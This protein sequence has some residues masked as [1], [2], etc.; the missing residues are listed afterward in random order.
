MKLNIEDLKYLRGL[1]LDDGYR[2]VYKKNNDFHI[3]SYSKTIEGFIC[4]LNDYNPYSLYDEKKF[5]SI[6]KL[7]EEIAQKYNEKEVYIYKID[8]TLISSY[9]QDDINKSE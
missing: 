2:L 5:I 4:E 9:N 7:L 8:G 6:E 1:K 3:S